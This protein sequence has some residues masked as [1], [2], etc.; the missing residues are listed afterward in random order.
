MKTLGRLLLLAL[1]LSFFGWYVS[2]VGLDQVWETL[3]RLGPY[4]PLALLPY[5]IVYNVDCLAWAQTLPRKGI[6]W[7]TLLRIRWAGEAVNNVVPS[8]YVGGEAVKVCLLRSIGVGAREGATAA[9]VSKTAQT[10]AQLFFLLLAS[11]L[12]LQLA[13]GHP[14]VRLG[15]LMLVLCG[16]GIIAV[17]FWVQRAGFFKMAL[18]FLRR[19]PWR[20]H[21]L[22][23]RAGSL[24]EVDQTIARFYQVRPG[25]FRASTGLY[26]IGWLLDSLEIYLV[27]FLLGMP[28]TWNQ[29]LVVEA[30]TGVAKVFG[31]WVPGSLGVQE[32]GIV[33]MGGI[34]GLPDALSATY[35][36][37][38][39]GREVLFAAVGLLLLYAQDPLRTSAEANAT[40]R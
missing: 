4:V 22:E 39:R 33:V 29:A 40:T 5:L 16:I 19:V 35:A 26:F 17:L 14:G 12:L 20:F 27:A 11:G 34:A 38:R 1:G 6:P 21:F 18:A 13:P 15:I 8:A 2:R 9:V 3:R 24:L 32:S 10:V 25:R 28:I 30:F 37:V 23:K 7:W 36:L 31:M